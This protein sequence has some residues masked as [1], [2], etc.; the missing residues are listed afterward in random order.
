M[1]KKLIFF[2]FLI[3]NA[4]SK[5]SITEADLGQYLFFEK[6]LSID[7]SISCSSCHDPKSYFTINSPYGLGVRGYPTDK[8]PPVIF[9]RPLSALQFWDGRAPNLKDQV[10]F[11]I[12][13]PFEMGST[14]IDLLI[15]KIEQIPFYKK[16]FFEIY[17]SPVTIELIAKAIVQFELSLTSFNAPY[18]LYLNGNK[19]AIS[20]KQKKGMD[21]FFKKYNC[22]TCHDGINFTNEKLTTRC[23]PVVAKT[24]IDK[25]KIKFFPQFKVPTLRNVE[26][27]Y[28]YFHGGTLTSLEEAIEF[29]NETGKTEITSESDLKNI[30]KLNKEDIFYIK[31]FL[32][33]L[34]GPPIELKKLPPIN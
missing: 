13:N 10:I 32:K 2:L 18:D 25:E 21:L 9:N 34:T 8:N 24:L 1:E 31:E 33:S 4:Y 22:Q 30:I 27:T 16:A 29:Y 6:R 3:W 20:Q 28:P 14:D 11:P 15:L 19:K 7:N 23:Y 5:S 17:Q 26:K 12:M